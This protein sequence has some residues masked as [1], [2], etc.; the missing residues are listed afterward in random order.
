MKVVE[1]ME[2]ENL[3]TYWQANTNTSEVFDPSSPIMHLAADLNGAGA[4]ALAFGDVDRAISYF[5]NALAT[6]KMDRQRWLPGYQ[7]KQA[8]SLQPSR[9]PTGLPVPGLQQ[10]VIHIFDQTLIFDSNAALYNLNGVARDCCI[11]AIL[12]FNMAICFHLKGSRLNNKELLEEA[13]QYYDK[14]SKAL[15]LVPTSDYSS[16]SILVF[17]LAVW[18]NQGAAFYQLGDDKN[19]RNLFE[20]V[21]RLASELLRNQAWN[22]PAFAEERSRIYDFVINFIVVKAPIAAASA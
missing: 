20:R 16:A 10:E 4:V 19:S 2:C 7:E 12:F 14:C 21:H 6:F 18:N 8:A 15:A 17:I 3:A 13:I 1:E 22:A 11:S 5:S 9:L